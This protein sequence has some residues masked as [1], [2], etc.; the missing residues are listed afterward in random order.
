MDSL[1]VAILICFVLVW[2]IICL[3][4][5]HRYWMVWLFL[6]TRDRMSSKTPGQRFE[7]L[8]SVTVQLP[9]FNERRVAS[10]IIEAACALDYPAEKLQIQV[11]DDS[12]DDSADVTRECCQRMASQG[13]D[14]EYRHRLERTGY[15]A[16]ALADGFATAT[17]ELIAVFDADFVPPADFLQ[18]TVHH[19]TDL[20]IGM[21][22]TRWGHLNRDQSM[23]TRVQAMLLDSHFVVEQTARARNG[24]W[25]NFNGTGGIWRRRCIDEAG[26]WQHDT[27]TEDTDL[28]YRAQLAGWKFEYL[29]DVVCP[30]EIPPTV[31]AFMGQQHRW[32]KGLTQTAIKLLPR[33]LRSPASAGVKFEALFH[34]TCATPYIA[35]LLLVLLALPALLAVAPLSG[36]SVTATLSLAAVCLVFGFPAASLFCI[37]GQV[38]QRRSLLGSILMMPAVMAI[39]VGVNVLNTRAAIEA[40]LG[41]QSPFVRTPKFAG[42]KKAETDPVLKGIRRRLPA[43]IAELALGLLMV[44]CAAMSLT[45]PSVLIGVPFLVLFAVGYFTI[46]LPSL[47]DSLR[48]A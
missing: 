8:P 19:F 16:G 39:G 3:Y 35:V 26:G 4:G 14:I 31:S 6:R 47:R 28:S 38:A 48:S 25:F 46:G 40:L 9:M 13:H 29:P 20:G 24:R 5:L 23:L 36:L 7:T 27:L 22:Q 17:G 1:S 33:I 30:A 12:T 42:S 34:L 41:H 11:L 2:V 15:K 45:N 21:V 10:R 37:A 18:S 44:G 43:G 32:N